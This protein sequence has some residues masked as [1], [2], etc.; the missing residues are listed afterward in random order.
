MFIVFCYSNARGDFMKKLKRDFLV[1]TG[2][3]VAVR[4]ILII[5]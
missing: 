1:V 3:Y 2:L 4:I 5:S